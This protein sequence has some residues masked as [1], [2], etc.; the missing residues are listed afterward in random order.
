MPA[1][2]YVQGWANLAQSLRDGSKGSPKTKIATRK[3]MVGAMY[4]RIPMVDSFNPLA[5]LA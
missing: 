2:E 1:K 3:I 5:P 4:C